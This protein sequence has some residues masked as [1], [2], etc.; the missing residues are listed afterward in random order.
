MGLS[1][2]CKLKPSEG[3]EMPVPEP[4]S[5]P[6]KSEQV[7]PPSVPIPDVRPRLKPASSPTHPD[8]PEPGLRAPPVLSWLACASVPPTLGCRERKGGLKLILYVT[9]SRHRVDT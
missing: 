1:P 3:F 8:S 2:D 4:C 7:L 5:R 6:V 9:H